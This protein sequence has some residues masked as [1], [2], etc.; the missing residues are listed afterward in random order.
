MGRFINELQ[1]TPK[2]NGYVWRLAAHLVWISEDGRYI[3]VPKGFE[4]NFAS[5]PRIFWSLLAPIGPYVKAAVIHDYLYR[6]QVFSRSR[7][8]SYFFEAMKDSGTNWAQRQIIWQQVR[9]FGW[10]AWNRYRITD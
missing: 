5:V 6:K 3:D 2:S 9:A 10:F 1:V 8:D 4:T 7:A